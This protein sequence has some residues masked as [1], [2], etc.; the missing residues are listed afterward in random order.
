VTAAA[1]EELFERNVEVIAVS[2]NTSSARLMRQLTTLF[3]SDLLEEHAEELGVVERDG[4]LQ[5]L[6]AVTTG[7]RR[8]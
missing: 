5:T 1:F 7:S 3:P 8:F 2:N 4:K 6:Q